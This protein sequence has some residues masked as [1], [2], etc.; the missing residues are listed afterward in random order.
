MRSRCEFFIEYFAIDLIMDEE[1]RCRGIVALKMDDGTIHRFRA[2]RTILATG[3]VRLASAKGADAV[4]V[5]DA[6]RVYGE[7][8]LR[9]A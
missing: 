1:G 6:L 2:H 4:A 9:P 7:K 5:V 3:N 8:W